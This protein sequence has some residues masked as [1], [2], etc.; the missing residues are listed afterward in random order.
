MSTRLSTKFRIATPSRR[1]FVFHTGMGL[2]SVAL[3]AM[4][5]GEARAADGPLAPRKPHLETKAKRCIFLLMEGGPSHIDTYD[6]KPKLTAL[7]MTRF[8]KERTKFEAAM[9]TGERYY[10]KSPFEFRRAGKMGIEINS[11]FEQFAG[12]VDDVCFYRGLRAESVNHPTAL[13]HLNTGNQF[14]GDPAIGAWVGYGLG[15]ENQN[16]PAFVVLPDVAYPQGGAANWGSGYLPAN[17]QGT[18]LRAQ[19]AP[20]L[21]MAPPEGVTPEQQ[22]ANLDFL[23]RLNRAH[24][25]RHPEHADLTARI[26]SYE[27]AFRMQAEMPEVLDISKEPKHVLEM[28][29]I[30]GPDKDAEAYGRRCL[31]ARRLVEAGV[32]FVQVIAMGWD[33]HDYIDKAHGARIRAVD[34]GLAGLLRDLKQRGLLDSTL[35]VCA[36]EF[37]R[38]PDNGI[39]RG[40]EAW[41]RDHNATAMA[42]WMAGGGVKRGEIV[43]ATDETGLQAVEA[44]HPIKDFH[45][46]LLH[47]LGLDDNK[48]RF[49]HAGR[50]KQLSQTGGELI[51]AVLG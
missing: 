49:L 27:L 29:G 11:L 46:T 24:A 25:E 51:R 28:Y 12:V 45:V 22:K 34:R 50:E 13:Y 19:G 38:S 33:S 6:P 43:G 30:G 16:L 32:R 36:G 21:D 20:I 42:C 5:T 41:G 18:P 14:G 7:H 8:Q 23:N 9:N 48:L 37:G 39:R 44:V 1:E 26:E 15:T 31:L 4:V 17:Y 2:G 47:L 40:G 3:T 10:V 35:V